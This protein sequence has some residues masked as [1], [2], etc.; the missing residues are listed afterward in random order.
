[1]DVRGSN[2]LSGGAGGKSEGTTKRES[3]WE[4]RRCPFWLG[5][6]FSTGESFTGTKVRGIILGP[7]GGELRF[8]AIGVLGDARHYA[9]S[10]IQ[11]ATPRVAVHERRFALTDRG[12]K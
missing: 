5:A 8:D 2:G 9:R 6:C 4:A 11:S 12:K 1:M 3:S 7:C 10:E